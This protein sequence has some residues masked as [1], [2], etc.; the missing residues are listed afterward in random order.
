MEVRSRQDAKSVRIKRRHGAMSPGEVLKEGLCLLPEGCR[1]GLRGHGRGGKRRRG[2]GSLVAAALSK[3]ET[4]VAL[5]VREV[6]AALLFCF[7]SGRRN[8]CICC[9]CFARAFTLSRSDASPQ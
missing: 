8:M 5:L 2:E 6:G 4:G 9:L 7:Y 1:V 3:I